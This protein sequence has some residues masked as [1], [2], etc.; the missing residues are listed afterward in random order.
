M[1]LRIKNKIA[2]VTAS[3]KGLG[4]AAALSL[5]N[6][7]VHLAIC[8]RNENSINAAA[9]EI[10]NATGVRVLPIV[11]DVS[12]SEEIDRIT[13][14]VLN[15][16]GRIDILVNNAGGPPAN[17]H[18]TVRCGMGKG[19]QPNIDEH[20]AI[21]KNCSSADGKTIMG[22]SDLDCFFGRKTTY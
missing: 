19:F 14:S 12:R 20:A 5:A 16:Y 17:D 11:A 2:L 3:S 13:D 8:S 15:V 6:E 9:D 18:I 22:K 21:N 1:D 10:R 7:G 4:K